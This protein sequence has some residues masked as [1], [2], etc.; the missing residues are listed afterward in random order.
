M[1]NN[2]DKNVKK[3]NVKK[4]KL[5]KKNKNKN[6]KKRNIKNKNNNDKDVKKN[7]VKNNLNNKFSYKIIENI[8]PNS[9]KNKIKL[10]ML[11]YQQLLLK[12][13]QIINLPFIVNKKIKNIQKKNLEM[14]NHHKLNQ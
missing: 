11:H 2:N 12:V 8:N 14:K 3:K 1:K 6:L 13:V 9:K 4:R 10:K 5:K 7:N